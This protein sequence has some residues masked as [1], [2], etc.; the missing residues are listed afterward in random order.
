MTNGVGLVPAPFVICPCGS[1]VRVSLVT[2]IHGLLQRPAGSQ[3]VF[4]HA[5]HVLCPKG[6]LHK[7]IEA[8]RS[9]QVRPV[10]QWAA[11]AGS[12]RSVAN[13]DDLTAAGK[14]EQ[15]QLDTGKSTWAGDWAGRVLV[16]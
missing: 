13:S 2:Q 8:L 3:F 15:P 10:V 11:P 7:G 14:G 16:N 1:V 5:D 12:P 6:L 9:H 4:A